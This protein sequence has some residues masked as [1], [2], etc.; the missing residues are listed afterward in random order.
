MSNKRKLARMT[1]LF[2]VG[3][4][5][6]LGVDEN[7]VPQCVWIQKLNGFQEGEA[8]KD[9][10]AGKLGYVHRFMDPE[11]SEYIIVSG[12]IDDLSIEE[13]VSSLV[14][15][16][17]EES[18]VLA[19]ADI[20]VDK[21]WQEKLEVLNRLPVMMEDS[22]S[23]DDDERNKII[24]E[25]NAEYLKVAYERTEARQAEYKTDLELL[26]RD[27]LVD[28]FIESYKDRNSVEAFITE[29]QVTRLYYAMRDCVA[30][31]SADGEKWNHSE[32]DHSV[33]IAESRKEVREMPEELLIMFR[34][35]LDR[36]TVSMRDVENFPET[37]SS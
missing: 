32:C 33:L 2:T 9:G 5:A 36:V 1:D 25:Y 34:E 29:R 11:S 13:L 19:V 30:T 23:D 21:E 3:E 16:H 7:N 26:T 15:A 10:Y 17:Y 12:Q 14:H 28:K 35:I 18:Q 27:E 37:T 24:S 8:H 20:G 4:V 22:K 6:F 31:R